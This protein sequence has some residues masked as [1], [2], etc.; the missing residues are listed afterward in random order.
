[1]PKGRNIPGRGIFKGKRPEVL[2][3]LLCLK[4]SKGVVE[5]DRSAVRGQVTGHNVTQTWDLVIE[6]YLGHGE[7][8]AFTLRYK[9]TG[10]IFKK[11]LIECD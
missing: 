3:S 2:E 8:L 5:S 9:A 11:E 7:D 1:M 10:G 4:S 6:V